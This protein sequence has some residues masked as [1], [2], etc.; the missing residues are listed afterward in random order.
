MAKYRS[1]KFIYNKE[2]GEWVDICKCKQVIDGQYVSPIDEKIFIREN[3]EW[4]SIDCVEV[5]LCLVPDRECLLETELI[6]FDVIGQGTINGDFFTWEIVPRVGN[7]NMDFS[8]YSGSFSINDSK[9]RIEFQ[10]LCDNLTEGDEVF[11]I[12]IYDDEGELVTIFEFLLKDFCLDPVY[13]IDKALYIITEDETDNINNDVNMDMTYNSVDIV[14]NNVSESDISS[15][16]VY[17]KIIFDNNITKDDIIVNGMTIDA[18]GNGIGS[19]PINNNKGSITISAICDNLTEGDEEFTFILYADDIRNNPIDTANLTILDFCVKPEFGFELEQYEITEKLSLLSDKTEIKFLIDVTSLTYKDVIKNMI[20]GELADLI[21]ES[22]YKGDVENYNARVTTSDVGNERNYS[23]LYALVPKT[24]E[25][26]TNVLTV[27][28]MHEQSSSYHRQGIDHRKDV[29]NEGYFN[30]YPALKN[31]LIKFKQYLDNPGSVISGEGVNSRRNIIFNVL[32]ENEVPFDNSQGDC[33]SNLSELIKTSSGVFGQPVY[34]IGQYENDRLITKNFISYIQDN[35]GRTEEKFFFDVT[36]AEMINLGYLS[37]ATIEGTTGNEVDTGNDLS[38]NVGIKIVNKN[39]GKPVNTTLYY[40]IEFDD[41]STKDDILVDGMTIN[42]LGEGIGT[43]DIVNS[44]ATLNISSVC[45]N[46]T[47][48]DETFI[49][50]LYDDKDRVNLIDT[51]ELKVADFCKTPVYEIIPENDPGKENSTQKVFIETESVSQFTKLKWEIVD[52]PNSINNS[53]GG[54]PANVK[55]NTTTGQVTINKDGN[56]EF[57]VIVNC[58]DNDGSNS[59]YD[60]ILYDED[61]V[62]LVKYS[63]W[64]INNIC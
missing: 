6:G 18:D 46:L 62:I 50:Y 11:D 16:T 8:S 49:I 53:E 52:N 26:T 44:E 40:K 55:F 9:G 2:N 21:L 38:S 59:S 23:N 43:L 30:V 25:D 20:Q 39:N 19:I 29:L 33:N 54:T 41:M 15:D 45:D 36:V 47:E 27:H 58:I 10:S 35:N 63:D 17:Y 56:S 48:Q 1:G 31:D 4:V 61:D 57:N 42:A 22:V 12:N 64:V 60:I 5:T 51:T 32:T 37:S 34:N 14:I 28:F 3:S 13:E 24:L 7:D